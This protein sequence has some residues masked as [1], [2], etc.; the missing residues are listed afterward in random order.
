MPSSGSKLASGTHMY[1]RQN[2]Y[3]NTIKIIFKK[4]NLGTTEPDSFWDRQSHRAA[5]AAPFLG[6]SQ[7]ATVP[8]RGQVST[9]LRR[10]Q[11]QEQRIPPWFRD[12][13]ELRNLVCTGES[14][15]H[16]S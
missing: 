11:P 14:L 6:R 16:R 2:I 13:A 3:T 7:P 15:H 10:P 12:S 1:I 5:E 8:T 9:W 4:E